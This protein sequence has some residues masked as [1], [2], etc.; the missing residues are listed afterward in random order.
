VDRF[1]A[2]SRFVAR[3]IQKYYRRSSTVVHPPV[4]T[5]FFTI[6]GDRREYYLIVAALV[7]YK[8]IDLAIEAFNELGLPLKIV[9]EGHLR[10]ALAS[11]AGP[12]IE[13]TGRLSDDELREC[14]RNCKAVIQAGA[15]DFGIVPLEAQ[16]AGRPVIALGRAGALDTVLPL[17]PRQ[18]FITAPHAEGAPAP[19]GVF[20]YDFKAEELCSAVRYFEKNE[21]EFV[22]EKLRD[23]ALRFR[24]EDYKRRM[25]ELIDES[26]AGRDQ[27]GR[28]RA[29]RARAERDRRLGIGRR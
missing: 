29:E 27:F 4:D 12:N 6:G 26:L 3:R 2:N 8:G 18:S 28:E 10:R 11:K 7:P 9:G 1:V 15:E 19:T 16:A 13:F 20:F 22:P 25:Q 21:H 17:N 23:N 24:R 14:Y 5:D